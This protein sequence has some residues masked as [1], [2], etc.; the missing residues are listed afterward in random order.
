MTLLA[1][2][3]SKA[4]DRQIDGRYSAGTSPEQLRSVA[5]G[6]CNHEQSDQQIPLS[7]SSKRA[8]LLLT[9]LQSHTVSLNQMRSLRDYNDCNQCLSPLVQV[10]QLCLYLMLQSSQQEKS[11]DFIKKTIEHP[12]DEESQS[13]I[14]T[15]LN[16]LSNNQSGS[17]D[18]DD[19][20][21]YIDEYHQDQ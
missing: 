21:L 3:L 16:L 9:T 1:E 10:L 6:S 2:I 4:V 13:L 7:L 18:F 12:L 5:D 14:L 20:G 17:P 19:C 8:E 15:I 11:R